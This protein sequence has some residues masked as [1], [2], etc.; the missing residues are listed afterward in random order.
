MIF[1][2]MNL[3]LFNDKEIIVFRTLKK[4]AVLFFSEFLYIYKVSTRTSQNSLAELYAYS[5]DEFNRS[6]QKEHKVPH[7][8][9]GIPRT[10]DYA[11]YLQYISKL[12]VRAFLFEMNEVF[13][14]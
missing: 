8:V 9:F 13:I 6:L 12:F 5:H 14:D 11:K 7:N 4:S 2:V 1:R 10:Y 3:Y